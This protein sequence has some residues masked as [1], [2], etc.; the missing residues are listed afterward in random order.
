M[1]YTNAFRGKPTQPSE[2]E[3]TAALGPS[4]KLWK[5]FIRW[6]AEEEGAAGQE[7]KGICV[8]KYGWSLRLKQKSRNIVYLGPGEG[9]FMVSF[10]L[11]D[12]A[13][14][15]AKEASLPKA[16][17][18]ILAAAPHYP[19]GNGVRLVVHRAADLPS[20]RKIAAIK[21]AN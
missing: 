13:L 19:E 10:V 18:E 15:A 9:C 1:E 3:L 2:A 11:S 8:N 7:W 6:M 14:Q 12:K 17:G 5:E 16:V 20:I 21:M 4:T